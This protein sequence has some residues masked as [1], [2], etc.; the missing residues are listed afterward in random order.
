MTI[1]FSQTTLEGDQSHLRLLGQGRALLLELKG[2]EVEVAIHRGF[3]DP[4]RLHFSMFEYARLLAE[5][6]GSNGGGGSGPAGGTSTVVDRF[7][8]SLDLRRTD[9][10]HE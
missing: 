9:E 4:A 10:E 2:H 8:D 1:R 5:S 7:L 6:A 3:L